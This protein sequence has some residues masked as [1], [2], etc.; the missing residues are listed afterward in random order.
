MG[1]ITFT[2]SGKPHAKQR[3]RFSRRTGRSYTPS[4]TVGFEATVRQVA[5]EHFPEPMIGAV[6]VTMVAVFTPAD[7]WSTKKKLAHMHRPHIQKPD[8][9]NIEKS[10]LDGLNRIAFADDAQVAEVSK[11]K[12]WGL[13]AETIVTVEQLP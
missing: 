4:E 13:R 5:V 6:K 9:D 7:S 2:V 1:P 12:V 3:P 10:I 8:L 11:R